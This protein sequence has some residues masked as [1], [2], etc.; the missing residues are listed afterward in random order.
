MRSLLRSGIMQRRIMSRLRINIIYIVWFKCQ[1][2]YIIQW[3]QGWSNSEWDL[4][5]NLREIFWE[6]LLAPTSLWK[7]HSSLLFK[8]FHPSRFALPHPLLAP[9]FTLFLFSFSFFP[10]LK[11]FPSSSPIQT[12]PSQPK[13]TLMIDQDPIKSKVYGG[14]G[15]FWT[16][17][18]I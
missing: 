5:Q 7:T 17:R 12:F 13:A 11:N 18:E 1:I 15:L 4:K 9:H 3:M 16:V 8:K 2:I 6:L 14:Y 10:N